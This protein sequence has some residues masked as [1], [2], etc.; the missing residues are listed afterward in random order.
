MAA[1]TALVHRG[2]VAK[3]RARRLVAGVDLVDQAQATV[4]SLPALRTEQ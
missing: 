3:A 4:G 2:S 1:L